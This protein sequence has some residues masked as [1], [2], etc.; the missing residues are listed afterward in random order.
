MLKIANLY[1]GKLLVI[2]LLI[3]YFPVNAA[4]AQEAGNFDVTVSPTFVEL[5]AKPGQTVNQSLRLRNNTSSEI[6]VKPEIKIMGGDESG[7]LTIKET[8]EPHLSWV[9]V[10][11]TSITLKPREWTTANFTI[12]IPESAA[13]GYYWALTFTSDNEQVNRETGATLTASLAVPVLLSVQK[14]GAKTEGKF[15]DFNTDA[16][17]YEYPPIT[18]TTQFANNGNVHIRPQGNIFIK[19]FIGRTV[20]TLTVNEGQGGILPTTK[21]SFETKWNDGFITYEPKMDNG[22]QVVD[23]QGKPKMDMKIHYQKLLDLR[24]GKYNATA[25]MLVSGADRDYTYEKTISFFV[26]PWKVVLVL[27]AIVIFVGIG[28]FTT[29]RSIFRKVRGIFRKR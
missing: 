25:L 11:D 17:F 21:R 3:I 6:T 27:I 26:F 19:D 4:F 13:F 9:S 22:E 12:A 24:I 2:L 5:T 20:A 1:L 7:E 28:L 8:K 16:S 18:F 10:K 29:S 14:A 23:E 15:L